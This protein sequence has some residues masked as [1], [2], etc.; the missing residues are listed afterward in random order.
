M[1]GDGIREEFKRLRV[2]YK[3]ARLTLRFNP[4]LKHNAFFSDRQN[5][6]FLR[7][8]RRTK[9]NVFC[10]LHEFR[11]AIQASRR[12]FPTTFAHFWKDELDADRFALTQFE[13]IYGH[14]ANAEWSHRSHLSERRE[15][16][17]RFWNDGHR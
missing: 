1:Y 8:R 11:H 15:H 17:R 13:R 16:Y 9:L 2:K 6:I 12:P 4:R 10:L 3:L 7:H 14:P 5:T